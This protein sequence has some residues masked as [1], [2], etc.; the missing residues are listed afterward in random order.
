MLLKHS[1]RY[2]HIS[3]PAVVMKGDISC[4]CR[5]Y[6]KALH[7]LEALREAA[8]QH[9][10]GDSFNDTLKD[11]QKQ[12]HSATQHQTFWQLLMDQQM[13]LVPDEEAPGTGVS[14]AEAEDFLKQHASRE[15]ASVLYSCIASKC[16]V[17]ALC[18]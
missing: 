4:W 3:C 6:Q 9:G 1:V 12:F 15:K 8:I 18:V 10:R 17:F 7:A 16:S 2:H 13:T 14:A 5:N 11:L